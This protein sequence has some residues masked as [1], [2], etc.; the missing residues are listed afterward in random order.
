MHPLPHPSSK[1]PQSKVSPESS[2]QRKEGGRQHHW[3]RIWAWELLS[4]TFS[5]ACISA[6]VII[7]L[8]I[9]N[10]PLESWKFPLQPNTLVSIFSTLSKSALLVAVAEGI[11]QL[12]WIYFRERRHRLYDLQVFEYASRGPWGSLTL[13]AVLRLQ[14]VVA[15]FGAVITIASL[16]MDPFVQEVLAYPFM[17]MDVAGIASI[18]TAS[19]YD[20]GNWM[21]SSVESSMGEWSSNNAL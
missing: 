13:L 4:S 18:A 7:L 5:L 17:T 6:V 20:W 12:K 14:A 15:S 19:S 2:T 1:I 16:A 11:S 3:T 9:Q 8:C 21:G 10:K